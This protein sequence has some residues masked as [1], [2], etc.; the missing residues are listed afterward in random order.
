[1]AEQTQEPHM[2]FLFES[3][4]QIF[5]LLEESDFFRMKVS[6][7][8]VKEDHV[9]EFMDKT[10]EWLS[11]NP[12]KGIL[13]DLEGVKSVCSDFTVAL[14]RNYEDIKRRGL[15]V[16][17]VNVDPKIEPYVVVSNIT[18]VM[19]IPDKQVISA[20]EL[21]GD[22]ANN[23]SDK[24]LMKKHDLSQRGLKRLYKKL[25]G[26]GLIFRRALA[27]RMGVP[28]K[29]ISAVFETKNDKKVTVGASDVMKKLAN[30]MTDTE[31]MHEYKLSPR[32][33]QSLF[34]KLYNKGLISKATF[35][36]RKSSLGKIS[37]PRH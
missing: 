13:I 18:V 34:R 14:T 27:R 20:S 37:K 12:K 36:R 2:K 11:T 35:L 26:K 6:K 5:S 16:R 31:L 25:L 33:L 10:V 21:L 1:M 29:D 24:E 23:L 8:E 17:F 4:E 28:T 22:L 3:E 7:S 30:E 19:S 9:E 32:G 15:Y